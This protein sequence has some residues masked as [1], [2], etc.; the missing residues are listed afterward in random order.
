MKTKRILLIV[1]IAV[2]VIAAIG[3]IVYKQPTTMLSA[4]E[5]VIS[6]E[7]NGAALKAGDLEKL[8]TYLKTAKCIRMLDSGVPFEGN[9]RTIGVIYSDEKGSVK[10]LY[11]F[12]DGK[13]SEIQSPR[14]CF[15]IRNTEELLA[16]LD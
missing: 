2:A 16:V 11:I 7:L 13:R 12:T 3:V 15:R 9:V 1:L 6:A 8:E 4:G 5:K 10:G 14:G